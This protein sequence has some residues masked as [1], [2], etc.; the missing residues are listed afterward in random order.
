MRIFKYNYSFY[1]KIFLR[2]VIDFIDSSHKI[3][4]GVG[5]LKAGGGSAE[6]VDR[7]KNIR[8]KIAHW[9][10]SNFWQ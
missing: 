7:N 6:Y 5:W 10:Y 4:T 1:R 3:T 8:W 2:R 9:I